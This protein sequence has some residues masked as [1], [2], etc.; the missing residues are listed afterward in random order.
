MRR[1]R[2]TTSSALAVRSIETQRTRGVITSAA[3]RPPKSSER[4]TRRAT[5]SSSVPT[6][7]ERRTIEASSRGVR[8]AESSSCG[9]MPNDSSTA[10]ADPLSTAMRG[11]RTRVK[12]WTGRATTFAVPSGAEIPRNCGSSSPKT[13]EKRVAR[14]SASIAHTASMLASGTPTRVT[15][16]WSSTPIEG[17][18]R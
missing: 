5:S 1:A 14:T 7:A 15:R 13:I 9:V 17:V 4:V 6:S 2:S 16:G 10:L 12:I 18:A 11:R 8:A 3:I